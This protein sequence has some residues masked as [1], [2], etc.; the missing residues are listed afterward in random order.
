MGASRGDRKPCTAPRCSG[1]MQFGRSSQNSS[2]REDAVEGV[3][4]IATSPACPDPMGWICSSNPEHFRTADSRLL[5]L[6]PPPM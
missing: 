2:G 6:V 3:V 1:T 4:R 5:R